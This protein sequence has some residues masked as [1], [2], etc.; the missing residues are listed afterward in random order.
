MEI[1]TMNTSAKDLDSNETWRDQI[2]WR[3][4]L[5]LESPVGHYPGF[6]PGQTR[7]KAGTVHA[8]GGR[9]LSQDLIKDQDSAVRMRDGVTLYVDIFRPAD[10]Q[11]PLPTVVAWGPYGKGNGGNQSLNDFPFRAGVPRSWLSGLQ[12]WE[13]PDPDWWCARGYAVV[14]VD[15]RGAYSSEGRGALWGTQEG[16]DGHDLVEWIGAQAWS[17]GR[18][19]LSGNSWLAMSQWFIAAERPPHLAA[20]A[21]W[22][23]SADV[24]RS[25]F[26]GGVIDTAF[27]RSIFE[28][29]VG[30]GQI[31]DFQAMAER[32]PLLSPYWQD[33]IARIEQIEIPSYVVGSWTNFVH[34]PATFDAWNRLGSKQKWLRVH[35]SMEWPDYYRHQEDL[36]KF[37]DRY[38]KNL[39]NGWEATPAVRLAVCGAE[40]R[41][42]VD[43]PMAE[44]PPRE[45]AHIALHLS[46]PDG[47]LTQTRP[48]ATSEIR[49]TGPKDELTF[50]FSVH[51]QSEVLG[52]SKLR[53]WVQLH[54]ATDQDI[55]VALERLDT[56]GRKIAVRTI[57]VPNKGL[58]WAMRQLHRTGLLR[59]LN[60]LFPTAVKGQ[61]RV[62]HRVLDDMRSTADRPYH[63]HLSEV[64]VK[65]GEIVPVE[66]AID[67][68][69]MRL[70]PGET[71]RLRI[72]GHNLVPIPLPGLRFAPPKGGGHF[73]VWCGGVYDSHLLTPLHAA[74]KAGRQVESGK[75]QSPGVGE[76]HREVV[77][78][79]T[80]ASIVISG[81]IPTAALWIL[82]VPPPQ[83][84]WGEDSVLLAL[85]MGVFAPTLLMT[86][87]LTLVVRSR[88]QLGR[89]PRLEWAGEYGGLPQRLPKALL[90]RA[91]LL[92]V[93]AVLLLVPPGLL[94]LGGLKVLPMSRSSF[95]FFNLVV[96]ALVGLVMTRFVV[97][98]ALAERS[99]K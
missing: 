59:P 86:L 6:N 64:P 46:A 10:A 54:D 60:L 85:V 75:V 48:T 39:D 67:P 35:N 88:V 41:D 16:R 34:T 28:L 30:L 33:K 44:F 87:I 50:D 29:A 69:A 7:L 92:A 11:E 78:K 62:S 22:E 55:F 49:C 58:E 21:P 1:G 32:E 4:Q 26:Q 71:L 99:A 57:P 36:L 47:R 52:F 74:D 72:A 76:I 65:P 23:G 96:G 13:G 51:G 37:F 98:A 12:V 3:A 38:L 77:R 79:E 19:G 5:P 73:S 93:L 42:E 18:V 94:L 15:A 40:G 17:N 43:R 53:L 68:I 14:N 90:P 9:S 89:L 56:K 31:E 66:I 27:A 8:K 20:I 83:S 61:L 63:S 81:A 95:V 97:L 24:F 82:N 91:V 80:L 70:E 45:I 84:L 2:I 25:N